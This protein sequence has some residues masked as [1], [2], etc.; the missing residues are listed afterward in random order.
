M[1]NGIKYS[2]SLT[3]NFFFISSMPRSG[4]TWRTSN[5]FRFLKKYSFYFCK[6]KFNL[7]NPRI[8]FLNPRN[9]L[10]LCFSMFTLRTCSQ[11]HYKI[12]SMKLRG[13][14]NPLIITS[15]DSDILVFLSKNER[16]STAQTIKRKTGENLAIPDLKKDHVWFSEINQGLQ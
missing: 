12:V 3:L 11:N 2:E 6:K 16:Y 10:F 8:F 9:F 14:T 4:S 13:I 1:S 7:E 5:G 15:S